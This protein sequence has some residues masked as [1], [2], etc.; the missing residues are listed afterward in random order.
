MGSNN[1]YVSMIFVIVDS[2]NALH[3][4]MIIKPINNYIYYF[5]WIKYLMFS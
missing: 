4:C 5:F 1:N 3:V 2:L